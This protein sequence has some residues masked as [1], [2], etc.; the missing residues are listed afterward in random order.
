MNIF[1]AADAPSRPA[2]I[3]T[4]VGSA[5]VKLLGSAAVGTPV[6]VYEVAFEAG[7]RTNWHRHSGAQWLLVT[8]GR[9]RAQTD[10][11]SARDIEAG[12]AV[13]FAPGEKHW[14]GSAPGGRG[15]H[16]AVNVDVETTWLEPVSDADYDPK[17]D[18]EV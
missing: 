15:V 13:V 3:D 5:Q 14:H 17:Y 11:G 16:L 18:S 1:R 8:A 10:G 4:F 12:D 7:A 2:D 6:R 9:I